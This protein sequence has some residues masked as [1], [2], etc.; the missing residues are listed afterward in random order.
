MKP[1]YILLLTLLGF[2]VVYFVPHGQ[3]LVPLFWTLYSIFMML[4][5]KWLNNNE[6]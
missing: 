6:R 4:K 5:D 2:P 3:Y 1:G